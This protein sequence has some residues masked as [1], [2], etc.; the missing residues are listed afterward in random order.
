MACANRPL[1]GVIFMALL[2]CI[3]GEQKTVD[4]QPDVSIIAAICNFDEEAGMISETVVELSRWQF[5]ITAML[6]FLFIPLTLGL[7]LLLALMESVYV[8]TGQAIYKTMAQLWG[9]IFAINFVLAVATRLIVVFQFG[10]TGSYFSHYVGDIFALPLAIEALTSFFLAA[11]L[12]GPY[13][14]G[15]DKLGSKQHVFL[16]WLIAIAVNLSAYWVLM[17]NGWM[18]NPVAAAFNYQSYRMELSDFSQL[19]SNPTAIAKYLHTAAASYAIC[20][21]T[22]VAISA[23]WLQKNQDDQSAR[24]AYKLAAGVGLLAMVVTIVLSDATPDSGTLTQ[25]VKKAAINGQ[26]DK[27]MQADIETHITNGVVAYELLQQLRDGDKSARLL[28]DF[29]KYKA[30]L[31]YALFLTPVHKKIS[32]ASSK[33]IALAAQSILPAYPGLIFW[34]YRLMIA[35]GIIGLLGFVLAAWG[36]FVHKEIPRWLLSLNIYLLPIPWLASVLGWFVAEAG[37][38]PWAVA[39]VLPTFLSVSAHSVTQLVVSVVGYVLAYLVLLAAGIYL[40]RQMIT[41]RVVLG[42]GAE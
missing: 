18:Q 13:W 19:L 22:L 15:W 25:R 23:Y 14:F 30:D 32:G 40:M 20:C 37:K 34:A 6:H 4:N 39:G 16:T 10:M 12:F 28:A 38:Q 33:Q 2:Y 42:K 35:C 7:A 1:W 3:G 21:A 5:A 11:V 31:G 8:W 9:R 17:A 36:G 29:E 24:Y 27:Q 41:A 26:L